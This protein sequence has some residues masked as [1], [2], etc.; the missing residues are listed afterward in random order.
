MS[1][2]RPGPVTLKGIIFWTLLGT[3]AVAL[4]GIL[5]LGTGPTPLAWK[6]VLGE[7]L[8]VGLPG[9]SLDSTERSILLEIRLP[10]VLLTGIVGMGLAVS[11]V[12]LQSLLRN[13]LA[14]P[15]VLGISS[16]AAL[17]ALS[18]MALATGFLSLTTPLAAFLGAMGT[19]A[20][21]LGIAGGMGRLE[22]TRVLLTGVIVNAFFTSLIMLVLSLSRAEQLH[23]MMFWLYGDLSGAKYSQAGIVGPWALGA[24]V[25]LWS[26]ARSLNLLGLG[27][28]TAL[29]LGV[30]VE[31]SKFLLLIVTALL[32]GLVVSVSGLIGFVGLIVP[33]LMRMLL[34]PDHRLLLPMGALGGAV[35]LILADVL[36][37]T[38]MSP[39]EVPVGVITAAL[40]A[41]F[42][43]LLLRTRGARWNPS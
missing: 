14:E 42:F 31:R 30:Q 26:Q 23:S 5:A 16:G 9:W 38:L 40:G 17:G 36:A 37:R 10:R 28:R 21:V 41:P 43:I 3:V 1:F 13:P 15:F 34:G 35:F 12:V 24:L 11:G 39:A 22:M 6:G 8:G 20:L 29:Q 27:E 2:V 7:I 18:S 25:I 19:M 4:A 32:T 33:H